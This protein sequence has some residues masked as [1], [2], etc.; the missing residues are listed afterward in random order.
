MMKIKH[1][2]Q[3]FLI[4]IFSFHSYTS[5]APTYAAPAQPGSTEAAISKKIISGKVIGISD[6][7]SLTLLVDGDQQLKVRLAGIDSP[8]KKQSFG[9]AAKK[10]LSDKVFSQNIR[11]EVR[12][13]DKYGRTLGIVRLGEQDI[14]EFMIEQGF[15]WHFKKYAKDQPPDEAALYSEAENVARNNKKGLWVQDDPTPPWEYRA[16]NRA[17][18]KKQD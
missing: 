4:L 12:G 9:N 11:L 14:N 16:I 3:L 17:K 7:D 2:K 15:A 18:A 5:I 8:E 10:A 13:T 1:F 6:G